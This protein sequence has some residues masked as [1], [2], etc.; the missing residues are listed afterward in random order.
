MSTRNLNTSIAKR[1]RGDLGPIE[2][3]V[4]I[5]TFPEQI[6][7]TEMFSKFR[8]FLDCACLLRASSPRDIIWQLG[9]PFSYLPW[10]WIWGFSHLNIDSIVRLFIWLSHTFNV[11]MRVSKHGTT[12]TILRWR[13]QTES[14]DMYGQVQVHMGF[15]GFSRVPHLWLKSSFSWKILN[16][17]EIPYLPW[18]STPLTF[19]LILLF[20]KSILQ[21]TSM[22]VLLDEWQTV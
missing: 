22:N 9:I 13:F 20:K 14:A 7:I 3:F 10:N 12:S 17:L 15:G 21:P 2:S 6:A 4:N 11:G 1:V 5:G 18:I 19:H 16:K 8:S